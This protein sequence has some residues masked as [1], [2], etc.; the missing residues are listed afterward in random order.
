M[1]IRTPNSRSDFSIFNFQFSICVLLA[2]NASAADLQTGTWRA[3]PATGVEMSITRAEGRTN[4]AL[5]IDFD[6]KGH[7]GYAIARRDGAIE[8]PE[9]FDLSFWMKAVAPRNTLEV[10]L[11]RGDDVW[12]SVR[13]ELDYPRDWRRFSFKKRNF[14][15]AWGPG[16]PAPLPNRIDAIEIVVTAGTGGKGTVWIDE[17]A[18]AP[19]DTAPAGTLPQITSLPWTSDRVHEIGGLIIDW[20][21]AP[22]SYEI[23][24]EH[25]TH[26]VASTN[27]GR[28]IL[29]LPDTDTR[30]IAVHYVGDYAINEVRAL[31]PMRS[32]ND[33]FFAV[34]A[35]SARGEYPRYLHREQSYWTILGGTNGE[36]EEALLSEDGAIEVGSA[37]FSIEPFLWIDGKLVTWNDVDIE[38]R[39]GPAVVWKKHLTITPSVDAGVLKVRYQTAPNAKLFLAIRPFQVNPPWQ[40]LKRT[41]G[42]VPV[43]RIRQVQNTIEVEGERPVVIAAQPNA[44]G[45]TSFQSADISEYLRSGRLPAATEVADSS[46]FASAAMSFDA[47]DVTISMPLDPSQGAKRAAPAS[48]WR[49]DVPAD[50]RIA[51]TL[52]AQLKYILINMDGASIQPGSRSYERSWIRD[53]SLTSTALLRLGRRAEVRDFLEF[54]AK[55]VSAEGYVPCCV[56]TSGAPDPVPE[57][58]SHGQFIYLVAEYYRHT[59]DR[60]TAESM[61]PV[62][63]RVVNYIDKLR[64]QR[65][66]GSYRGTPFYGMVPE[67]ISHEGYS[68]KPMHSYWDT[69]FILR[70]LKDATFLA[71]EL[72]KPEAPQYASLRDEF[73]RDL[74][75][76]LQAT[77]TSH[78]IDYIPGSIELGDFD[79]TSTTVAVSP[80]DEAES[81]PQAALQRTFEKY[82]EHALEPRTYTPYEWRV[83]GTLI[84][85]GHPERA[86]AL[87]DYFYEDQRPQAWRQ[88]AE[89]VHRNPREPSFIGDMPHTWVGSDFIRSTLDFFVY[90]K[91]DALILA[92]GVDDAWLDRGI[93]V[94]NISTHFGPVSYTM[95]REKGVVVLHMKTKPKAKILAPV[96]VVVR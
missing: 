52:E 25:A 9:N 90:E 87:S 38:Q 11:V 2:L 60:A 6:F 56:S 85:L 10:K 24:T 67:S 84:R 79:A 39:E 50:P 33:F 8:L 35:E 86:R 63:Q 22:P 80:L 44:F 43:T 83:A 89:V 41:G 93:A 81:L 72:K 88:W 7:G 78:N 46:G 42:V 37:R 94:E 74:V 19:L 40:F 51:K 71:Q 14:E 16:G 64:H 61:W 17:V 29:Y 70:G 21:R 4:D 45:A 96:G 76:S 92:A 30:S 20:E 47:H 58:D 49:I 36:E 34:A 32:E 3:V 73:R 15:F 95:K 13:R 28:D 27:G 53:G 23:V 57:H 65:M 12:W 77:M 26:P 82:W 62:V 69:F 1:K 54:Y 66:N 75:A 31:P 5:K 18:L 59:R 55:A 68:A 91:E 48:P